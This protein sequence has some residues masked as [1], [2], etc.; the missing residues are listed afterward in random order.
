MLIVLT[1]L[2][3][4][5]RQRRRALVLTGRE[6]L[7]AS[8][9]PLTNITHVKLAFLFTSCTTVLDEREL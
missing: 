8:L 2:L 6:T 9:M 5:P 7:K 3:T 4:K 1:E